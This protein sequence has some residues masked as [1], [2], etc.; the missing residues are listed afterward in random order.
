[1]KKLTTTTLLL[2]LA[3]LSY[4]QQPLSSYLGKTSKE[5]IGEFK[6]DNIHDIHVDST[7]KNNVFIHTHDNSSY[8]Q[9]YF[10]LHKD[11]VT[12]IVLL[13]YNKRGFIRFEKRVR[14]DCNKV[15]DNFIYVFDDFVIIKEDIEMCFV[16]QREYDNKK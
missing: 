7:D 13:P 9:P 3:I 4:A 12:D 10:Y 6:V 14:K 8:L 16:I 15:I 1:M 11:K 2:F 5:V